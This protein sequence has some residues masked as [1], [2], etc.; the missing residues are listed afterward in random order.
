MNKKII[1]LLL[2]GTA[3]L[4]MWLWLTKEATVPYDNTI[5][6]ELQQ[7]LKDKQTEIYN[8]KLRE[9]SINQ[10]LVISNEHIKQLKLKLEELDESYN[11]E[12]DIINSQFINADIIQFRTSF[13]SD[14]TG[15]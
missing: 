14:S 11:N 3:I 6:L 15:Y 1:P 10:L 4:F 12:V 7:L 5:E 8:S 9:D 13:L 2:A